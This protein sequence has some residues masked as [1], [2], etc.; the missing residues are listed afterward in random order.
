LTIQA[1]ASSAALKLM[2]SSLTLKAMNVKPAAV[3]MS[4][5]LNSF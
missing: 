4:M 5:A 3:T 1:S 2:A